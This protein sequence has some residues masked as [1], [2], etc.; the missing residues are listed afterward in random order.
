MAREP[1]KLDELFHDT[2]KDIYFA[3]KKILSALEDGEGCARW[4]TSGRLREA[5]W[6]DRDARL[7]PGA[8]VQRHR[9]QAAEQ[10]V[11]CHHWHHRRRPGDHEGIQGLPSL[12]CRPVAAAQA[13]E[14][15]EISR[16]CTWAEE[17][18][19]SDAVKV[20]EATLGEEK[21]TDEALS[22]IAETVVNQEA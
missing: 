7:P 6:R 12:G 18:G 19:L 22:R 9:C 11:R 13:V 14:H 4:G 10:D 2:L 5:P 21:A 15:Y 16:F 1:K 8:G 20:L 3:E 17:L